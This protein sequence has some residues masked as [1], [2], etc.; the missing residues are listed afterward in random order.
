MKTFLALPFFLLALLISLLSEGRA[1]VDRATIAADARWVAYLDLDTLRTTTLGKE[2]VETFENQAFRGSNGAVQLDPRKVFETIGSITAYGSNL[3]TDPTAID[4]TL[5][6]RGTPELRKIAE[7][8]LLQAT[9]TTPQNCVEVKDLPFPAYA[10]IDI[11]VNGT[12]QELFFA[13]PPQPVVIASKSKAQILK[14]VDVLRGVA[15]SLANTATSPIAGQ[16]GQAGNA[17]LFAASIIPPGNFFATNGP[18]ARIL[19]LTN[20]VSLAVGETAADLFAHVELKASSTDAA[21]KLEKILQGLVALVGL[22]ETNDRQL[23]DFVNA[24][25]LA[26][27]NDAVSMH[28]VY[29]SARLVQMIQNAQRP[30]GNSRPVQNFQPQL[31]IGTALAEWA[32]E[33][34][35]N[36]PI[37]V[38]MTRTIDNVAL[39]NGMVITLGSF[40]NGRPNTGFVRLEISQ[41]GTAPLVFR[42]EFMKNST[43][44]GGTLQQVQFPGADGVYS[45]SVAYMDDASGKMKYAVS[46]KDPG[47]T[48]TSPRA[49]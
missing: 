9:L 5:I 46:V 17:Y 7:A 21:E 26:R 49:R 40:A 3:S 19:Q 45:L 30:A 4:G 48:Q 43:V 47:Q 6:A 31:T 1:A 15:P 18:Q 28:L 34:N 8:L 32:S 23:A 14:A 29:P 13:F 11:M 42:R 35:P 10:V 24:A 39:T 22:T 25:T 44:R 37:P 12:K 20:S 36:S 38:L 33:N 2:L 41:G 27:N 16:F